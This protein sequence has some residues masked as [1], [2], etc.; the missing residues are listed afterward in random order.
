MNR[1]FRVLAAVLVVLGLAVTTGAVAAPKD[2]AKSQSEQKAKGH[3]HL[4]GKDLVGDKIKQ[5]GNHKIKDNG[6]FSA[7]A[8]VSDGKIAGI[9]VKHS[10]KGNVPV[11]KYRTT[12]KMALGP[13]PTSG[14]QAASFVFAQDQY[15]GTV[16]IGF[17]YYDDYGYENIF[18]FPY[19][20][21]IDGYT[22][23]IEFYPTY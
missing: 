10:E 2:K 15:I 20:M 22:G 17:A 14:G 19:D 11:T 6:K 23:A 3:K 12:K 18:W 21:V 7:Y 1:R 9:N 8:T 4:S 16:W 5:N 13:N